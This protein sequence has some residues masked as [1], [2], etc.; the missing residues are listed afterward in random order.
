MGAV[1]PKR[2]VRFTFH[3]ATTVLTIYNNCVTGVGFE[4]KAHEFYLMCGA[5]KRVTET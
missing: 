4:Q 3:D 5:L 2:A 1:A